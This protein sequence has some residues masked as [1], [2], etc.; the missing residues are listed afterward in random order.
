MPSWILSS[1]PVLLVA[2]G[3][4]SADLAYRINPATR[5]AQVAV[6]A[7][8]LIAGMAA[9]AWWSHPWLLIGPILA[10]W[11]LPKAILHHHFRRPYGSAA[12]REAP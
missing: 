2:V 8:W 3:L 6:F 5:T 12:S 10:S 1:V 11:L 7:W 4:A 9:Q